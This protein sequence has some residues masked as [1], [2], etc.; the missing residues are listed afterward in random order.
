V[1]IVPHWD[2]KGHKDHNEAGIPFVILE[3]K[4]GQPGTDNVLAYSQK[5]EM[6]KSIF[7]YCRYMLLIQGKIGARTYR[8][9]T[10]FDK[11]LELPDENLE[12]EIKRQLGE[13]QALLSK[14]RG[15]KQGSVD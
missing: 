8:L 14:L 10:V 11:I 5:A 3:L 13:A 2:H 12:A 1:E 9:G 15:G 4:D 6:I 7:P